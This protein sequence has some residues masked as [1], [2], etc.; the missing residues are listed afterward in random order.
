M[1]F[2]R[3]IFQDTGMI[4]SS[5]FFCLRDLDH[6]YRVDLKKCK[7]INRFSSIKGLKK[8][9]FFTST[10]PNVFLEEMFFQRNKTEENHP[11]KVPE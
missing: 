6:G 2:C 4:E 7:K 8:D 9:E 10:R 3:I 1:Y 11:L 5:V